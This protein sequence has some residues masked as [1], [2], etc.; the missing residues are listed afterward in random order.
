MTVDDKQ[1]LSGAIMFGERSADLA[2]KYAMEVRDLRHVMRMS[3]HQL[4]IGRVH[5]ARE[6]LEKAL[7][8]EDR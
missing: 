4:K 2:M 7:A 5:Q 8:D 6:Y 1:L 3:L